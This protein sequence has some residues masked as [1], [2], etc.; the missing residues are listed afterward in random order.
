MASI[1][2]VTIKKTFKKI[3]PWR[4][5]LLDDENTNKAL[6]ILNNNKKKTINNALLT[7]N[8]QYDN[9]L[10]QKN[11]IN[12]ISSDDYNE[13][14]DI[15]IEYNNLDKK[16]ST[17]NIEDKSNNTQMKTTITCKKNVKCKENSKNEKKILNNNNRIQRYI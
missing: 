12:D 17:L 1:S 9:K 7:D 14:S 16:I 5:I 2:D 8:S 6:K 3:Y 4:T 15:E 13:D 10:I 11:I